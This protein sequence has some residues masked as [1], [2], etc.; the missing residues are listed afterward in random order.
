VVL[1]A[2]GTVA[3]AVAAVLFAV[4]R[5][6]VGGEAPATDPGSRAAVPN[7]PTHADLPRVAIRKLEVQ[8]FARVGD[9]DQPRGA[10]GA[11]SFAGRLGDGVTVTAELSG[12][13]YCYLIA[14]RADG[15]EELCFPEDEGRPPPPTDRPAY[16]FGRTDVT[17]GLTDGEGLEGFVL[18]A[19]GRPLPAYAEW[20]KGRGDSPWRMTAAAPETVWRYD[21]RELRAVTPEDPDGTRGKGQELRGAGTFGR[22][23]DWL[24][25]APD[26]DAVAGVA[27]PVL[28]ARQ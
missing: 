28:P 11:K 21:G 5:L 16:P 25:A 23:I 6:P 2:A 26:V 17:Y 19:S 1:A 14:F 12:P 24:R 7:P 20:R 15:T 22:V 3:V 18:V 4:T 27:F 9:A 8:H 10:L 13:A